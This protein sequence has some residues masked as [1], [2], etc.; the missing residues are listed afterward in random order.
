[1]SREERRA[2]KRMTKNQNPY[3][4]PAGANAAARA[5]SQARSRPRRSRTP[6][7]FTFMTSRFLAWLVGGLVVAGLAGFSMAWPSGMPG[8][9]FIGLAAAAGWAVLAVAFRF[10]QQRMAMRSPQR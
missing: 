1:M 8:A 7:E 3:A 10:L 6:G 9:L 5:R 2:Y 4:L